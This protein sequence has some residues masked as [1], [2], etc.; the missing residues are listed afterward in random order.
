VSIVAE[1]GRIDLKRLA[2][3][4][5]AVVAVDIVR[6]SETKHPRSPAASA[7]HAATDPDRSRRSRHRPVVGVWRRILEHP[8]PVE[9][10]L[11][12]IAKRCP[13][14]VARKF[15]A[16]PNHPTTW[17]SVRPLRGFMIAAPMSSKRPP[18]LPC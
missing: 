9:G 8:L 17:L 18:G 12:R 16:R 14:L 7:G 6:R 15:Q 2:V 4:P 3:R 11:R 13:G 1:I 5:V 10:R